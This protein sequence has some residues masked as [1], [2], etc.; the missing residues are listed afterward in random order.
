M[1][2]LT[3]FQRNQAIHG[4]LVAQKFH[5]IT[6]LKAATSTLQQSTWTTDRQKS[7]KLPSRVYGVIV[8]PHQ[9]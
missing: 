9:I 1:H 4:K 2:I 7:P 5:S 8:K 6:Y 3:S